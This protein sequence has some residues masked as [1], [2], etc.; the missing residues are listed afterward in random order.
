MRVRWLDG[1]YD[2]LDQWVPEVRLVVPWEEAADLV[3]DEDQLLRLRALQPDPPEKAIADAVSTVWFATA[4]DN[5]F[6]DV[7]DRRPL[8]LTV[9]HVEDRDDAIQPLID[10]LLGS[11]GA[12]VD[13]AGD[14]HVGQVAAIQVAVHL[15]RRWPERVL[16]YAER[17]VE[18]LR[19]AVRTGW[20]ESE[21]HDDGGFRVD[22]DK[23]RQWLEEK[24]ATAAVI[25]QWCGAGVVDAYDEVSDL[26]GEV[27]RLGRL[28]EDTARWLR[29]AGHPQK[30]AALLNR[31]RGQDKS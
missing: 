9:V 26:R 18:R 10:D 23:C 24:E 12:Y 8:E 14:L 4:E 25:R 7:R 27:D 19:V 21:L 20:Y 5:V 1:E 22:K 2:G 29:Q 13:S 16:A 6:F 15:A 28:L 11:P 31:W 17:E 30:A 3:R